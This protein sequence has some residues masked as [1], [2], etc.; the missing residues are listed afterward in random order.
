M[1]RASNLLSHLEHHNAQKWIDDGARREDART[2]R[3]AAR[4]LSKR[5]FNRRL[6]R[7]LAKP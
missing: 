7:M 6:A 4:R 3:R 2:I 1:S 5:K